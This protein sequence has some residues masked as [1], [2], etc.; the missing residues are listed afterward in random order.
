MNLSSAVILALTVI[1]GV[2][3]QSHH[4]DKRFEDQKIG[5]TSVSTT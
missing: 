5:S 3:Y 2:I 4:F 1:L